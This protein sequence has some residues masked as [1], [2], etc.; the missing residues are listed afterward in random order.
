MGADTATKTTKRPE[1]PRCR[2]L[3]TVPLA[4]DGDKQRHQCLSCSENFTLPAEPET[5]AP[6]EPERRTGVA[7]APIAFQETGARGGPKATCEK[8]GKPYYSLGVRWEA[9]VKECDGK[10]KWQPKQPRR[11]TTPKTP[12]ADLVQGV[13]R[14]YELYIET[15]R[16]RK[17]VLEAELR[18]VD[19]LLGEA[20]KMVAA[21]GAPVPFAAG[22]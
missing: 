3:S 4:R 6:A 19:G 5:G 20:E 11:R 15:L 9:H 13:A 18:S 17:A 10:K 16:A 1:C 14:T 8:C 21:R 2:G 22:A 12:A 7:H